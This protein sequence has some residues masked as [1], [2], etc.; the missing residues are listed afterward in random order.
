MRIFAVIAGLLV[1][2]FGGGCLLLVDKWTAGPV[3]IFGWLPLLAGIGLAGYAILHQRGTPFP[4]LVKVIVWV[5]V[6]GFIAAI[7]SLIVSVV[8][9]DFRLAG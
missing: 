9:F 8:Y 4:M 3:V 7:G 6:L 5:I 1:A 2:S